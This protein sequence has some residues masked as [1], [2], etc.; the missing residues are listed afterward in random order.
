MNNIK[1]VLSAWML[2]ACVLPVAAQYPVIPDS[3][4]A[5]GAKK[6]GANSPTKR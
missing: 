5:R 4:K 6:E 2:V 1:K 3:V